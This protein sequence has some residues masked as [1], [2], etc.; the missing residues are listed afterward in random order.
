MISLAL[1][2][3]RRT[4]YWGTHQAS[5]DNVSQ[6]VDDQAYAERVGTLGPTSMQVLNL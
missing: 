4:P 2:P 3:L 5:W 6:L 1:H